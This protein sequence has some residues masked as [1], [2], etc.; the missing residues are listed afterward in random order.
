Y[1]IALSQAQV[2]ADMTTA[3]ANAPPP[4]TQPPTSPNNLV[5]TAVGPTQINLTWSASTDNVDVTGY[6]LERCE[7]AGCSSFVQIATPTGTSYS[8]TGLQ[9]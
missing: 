7:G 6:R 2:Q 4:D 5:A 3:I 8:D 9:S 1:N